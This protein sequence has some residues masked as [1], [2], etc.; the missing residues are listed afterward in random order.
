MKG[1]K[2]IPIPWSERFREF[3]MRFLPVLGVAGAV[4]GVVHFWSSAVT[5]SV[6]VGVVEPVSARVVSTATGSLVELSVERFQWV[7]R[8]MVLGMV[9]PEDSRAELEFMRNQLSLQQTGL[10]PQSE[11]RRAAVDYQKLRLSWLQQK[12]DLVTAR[13]NLQFAASDLERAEK[14]LET[15][16]ITGR[17]FEARLKARDGFSAEVEEREKLVAELGRELDALKTPEVSGVSVGEDPL[18]ELLRLQKDRMLAIEKN[19]GLSSLVAPMDG[20]V[21]ELSRLRGETVLAGETILRIEAGHSEKIVGYLKQPLAIEP[22]VGMAVEVRTRTQ[23]RQTGLGELRHIGVGF[24]PAVQRGVR[25]GGALLPIGPVGA[26]SEVPQELG[27]PIEVS[28]PVGMN[29]RPGE[30][31]DLVLR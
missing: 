10:D 4:F 30:V 17:V 1:Y 26:V 7:K 18:A 31:V 20:M 3:R 15:N 28:L 24:E 16:A 6:L 25:T 12:V 2:P 19:L 14:L 29:V 8:G 21:V 13:I 9:R 27:L 22:K 23:M 11:A 5:P